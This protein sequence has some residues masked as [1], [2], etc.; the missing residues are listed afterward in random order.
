MLRFFRI[1]DPYRLLAILI[2]L[3]LVSLPLMINRPELTKPELKSMI[4]GEA[5]DNGQM[6]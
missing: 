5:M 6:M 3:I 2:F 4:I 1:N